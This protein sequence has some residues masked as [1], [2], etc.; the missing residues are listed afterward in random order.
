[1]SLEIAA[2]VL[3]G[4]T[5]LYGCNPAAPPQ[6]ESAKPVPQ[7]QKPDIGVWYIQ[8]PTINPI[9]GV[10]TQFLST[11]PIG[12]KLVL[13]FQ[14]G[15]LCGGKTAGVYVTSPCWVDGG[16]EEG[17]F[18][19]RRVRLKFDTDKFL[20]ETWGISDDHLGI[21]PH[22]PQSFVATIKKHESLMVEFGCSR[23]GP[24]DVVT[25]NIHG[26]QAALE[27]AGLKQ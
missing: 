6:V 2:G 7:E 25:F 17:T 1:M 20:V 27:S 24:D 12:S 23:N 4:V 15:K 11:G 22:S 8:E 14:N 19:K 10:K 18:Y 26:L 5:S 13:C 3:L 9:D 16:E 21:F